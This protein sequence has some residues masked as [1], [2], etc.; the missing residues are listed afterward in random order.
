MPQEQDFTSILLWFGEENDKNKL[1]SLL[2][3]AEAFEVFLLKSS[4][5]LFPRRPPIVVG[6][7]S[8]GLYLL[9]LNEK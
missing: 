2:R 3:P 7:E 9:I 8:Y 5:N 1:S 4:H 6:T